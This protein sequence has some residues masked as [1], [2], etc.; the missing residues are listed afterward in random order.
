MK[1]N[2]H[3]IRVPRRPDWRKMK[4]AIELKRAENSAFLNWR[5][6]LATIENQEHFILTPFERNIE[7]WRQLWRVV[8]VSD[9]LV[10]IV[11]SRN[12]MLFYCEDLVDYAREV[13]PNMKFLLL[14][15]KADLLAPEQKEKWT[16]YF[17]SRNIDFCFFSAAVIPEDD[18]EFIK[19]HP[20]D[21]SR[22]EL[23]DFFESN[24]PQGGH[25]G[26]VG[27]PNVGKSSTI[28]AL[29]GEKRVSVAATPGKTKHFQTINL[30][31]GIVLCDCP[32]LVFPNVSANRA[33]LV[34]NGILP[35]DQL[36]DFFGPTSQLC[37]YLPKVVLEA[38]YGISLFRK[39]IEF[40]TDFVD[41]STLLSAY[42]SKLFPIVILILCFVVFSRPRFP[43]LKLR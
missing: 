28:N 13:K 33:E 34:L 19:T 24:F 17:T 43:Y 39:D 12:P 23:L 11:D 21:I 31:K 2:K 7:M 20:K 14:I 32:G 16:T 35:I 27:Y 40:Q 5:K 25:V 10:Q 18:E 29:I 36:R 6:Q 38:I 42:A 4:S 37:T 22:S 9:L 1:N 26:F 30:S 41:Y 15:N 3:I 8:E